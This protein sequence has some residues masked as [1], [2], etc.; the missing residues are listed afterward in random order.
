MLLVL[1]LT[2][3]V[4]YSTHLFHSFLL[5]DA[6]TW[7]SWCIKKEGCRHIHS[8]GVTHYKG[9]RAFFSHSPRHTLRCALR[10]HSLPQVHS[11]QIRSTG[12]RLPLPALLRCSAAGRSGAAFISTP[13]GFR[14]SGNRECCSQNAS[15]AKSPEDGLLDFSTENYV[16]ELM[17]HPWPQNSC[18]RAQGS[19]LSADLC[20]PTGA[21]LCWACLGRVG[22]S[23]D[24]VFCLRHLPER[25]QEE[26]QGG[27]ERL[28][29]E[30]SPWGFLSP[31]VSDGGE[32]GVCGCH[33]I[34]PFKVKGSFAG[35][36]ETPSS[37]AEG[38]GSCG[39]SA[40]VSSLVVRDFSHLARAMVN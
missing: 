26:H 29:S 25:R 9:P 28:E 27:K 8:E 39:T 13:L 30:V 11:E 14:S 15:L 23:L 33:W 38:Q 2:S 35:P 36:E 22:C 7:S 21:C 19:R 5:S 31:V 4:G 3:W 17:R 1:F 24:Y 10:K 6:R 20:N 40:G 16:D 37:S 34:W 32:Q 18:W 12:A